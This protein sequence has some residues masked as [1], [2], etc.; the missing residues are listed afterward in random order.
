MKIIDNALPYS[1]FEEIKNY[2]LGEEIPWYHYENVTYPNDFKFNEKNSDKESIEKSKEIIAK[3]LNTE[4]IDYN[5]FYSHMVYYNSRITSP[6]VFEILQPLLGLL[7][8]KALMR[9]KINN[10]PKTPKIIH[11][12][13]H[14]DGNFKHNGAL[15]YVNSNNGMTVMEKNKKISSVENKLVLFD[16]SKMHHSTTTSDTNRRITININYF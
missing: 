12:Q 4:L 16:S 13:N 2:I 6:K 7:N 15:F 11:H 10:Y 5:Y 8:W 1:V 3:G 9:I 14:V